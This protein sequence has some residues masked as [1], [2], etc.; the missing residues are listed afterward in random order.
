M[1][2]RISDH[3]I[4]MGPVMTSLFGDFGMSWETGEIDGHRIVQHFGYDEG[5]SALLLLAPDDG[6]ALVMS[7]NYFDQEEFNPSAWENAIEAMRTILEKS[8]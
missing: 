5:Y 2:A 4:D 3:H 6:V 8:Q 7:S 1:W